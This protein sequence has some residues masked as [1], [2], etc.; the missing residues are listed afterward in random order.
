MKETI[1]S[2]V[3][4]TLVCML[5]FAGVYT[6]LIYGAAQCAPNNGKGE[7]IHQDGKTYY[8]NLGQPFN[9]K[10]YFWSRPS[11]AGYNAAGAGGSNKGTSNPDYLETVHE[12]ID[13]FLA[14]HPGIDRA[15]IPSDIVTASG[16][17]LDPHIS[18]QAASLQV[19]RV[20]SERGIAEERIR[21]LLINH[22]ESPLFGTLGTSRVNVLKLNLALDHLY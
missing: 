11:A 20:A 4:L 14:W 1:I 2:A 9:R 19:K 10:D 3:S 16:S 17:G 13:T 12:R 22:T 21:Q 8:V 5:F 7:V 18:V 15:D 6:L